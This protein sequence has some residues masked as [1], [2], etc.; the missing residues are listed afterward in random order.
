ML[1]VCA[2]STEC[3]FIDT[4]ERIHTIC[5]FEMLPIYGAVPHN[6]WGRKYVDFTQNDNS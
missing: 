1:A 3:S 6:S 2:E 4:R 5:Q